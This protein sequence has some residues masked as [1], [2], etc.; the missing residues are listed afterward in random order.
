M[1]RFVSQIEIKSSRSLGE[2]GFMKCLRNYH[3]RCAAHLMSAYEW[4]AN[5]WKSSLASLKWK[6]A[7]E[8]EY[9]PEFLKLM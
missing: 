5:F 2:R 8:E 6:K 9:L 4:R 7:V 3:N 1:I